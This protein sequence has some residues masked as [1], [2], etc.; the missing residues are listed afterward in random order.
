MS[1]DGSTPRNRGFNAK[2]VASMLSTATKGQIDSLGI[3][4]SNLMG[5]EDIPVLEKLETEK[6]KSFVYEY[7]R[8]GD[9]ER[10]EVCLKRKL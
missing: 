7:E 10:K 1:E 6:T 4:L 3:I 2:Q 8:M 9:M 5:E